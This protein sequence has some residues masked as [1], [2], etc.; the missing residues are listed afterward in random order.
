MRLKMGKNEIVFHCMNKAEFPW[1]ENASIITR[2][3]F[4]SAVLSSLASFDSNHE[5]KPVCLESFIWNE[6][7]KEYIF[8]LKLG[9][10]FTNGRK[11]TIE[12]L[13][14]SILRPLF[15]SIKNE[16]NIA[17]FNIKGA[18]EIISGQEYKSGIVKG[19]KIINKNSLSI[20]L[21]CSCQNLIH[22][23]TKSN[24]FLV[25]MEEL[26]GDLLSW[27]K[28]PVG[29]GPYEVT[30][31]D[32][33]FRTY[34]L[35]LFDP[36]KYPNAPHKIL[37]QQERLLKPDVSIKDALALDDL[38]YEQSALKDTLGVRI[39][40]FNFSSELG[41]NASFRKAVSLCLRRKEISE[42]TL[43]RTRP[44]NEFLIK[45][46]K[47]RI[48]VEENFNLIKAQ[49]LFQKSLG[50]KNDQTY[51]IPCS[52]DFDYL[53]IGYKEEICKQLKEAGLKV[54]FQI[55]DL[56]SNHFQ[57]EFQ[58]SPFLL[59]S[60]VVDY[61]E[62][63]LNF[64]AIQKEISEVNYYP[65]RSMFDELISEAKNSLNKENLITHLERLSKYFVENNVVIPLFEIPSIA[66]Y[67]SK[68]I[69]SIGEQ[70]GG[71]TFHLQNI[72]IYKN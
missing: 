10:Y 36:K 55:S 43:L 30:N 11:V 58:Q 35:E 63:L 2:Q 5:M 21:C 62:P 40:S 33:E 49:K 71:Q 45:G 52:P 39:F 57:G 7:N 53:G 54:E 19:L 50:S 34:T 64:M 29:V 14:F 13:E 65:G 18:K 17:L 47:G 27:K 25:P 23:L 69:K 56:H 67:N 68:K 20:S 42:N 15:S 16:G 72:V 12:D 31:E 44:L 60:Q 9:L 8:T 37:F 51:I 3:T 41:K 1:C 66:Y 6:K 32:K 4:N 26:N 24:N 48:G 22:I 59:H 70:F 28:W 61:Y 38:Y 46:I